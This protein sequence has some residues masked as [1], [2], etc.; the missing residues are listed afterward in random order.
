MSRDLTIIAYKPLFVV[1]REHQ[2]WGAAAGSRDLKGAGARAGKNIIGS[3][4][5]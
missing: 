3:H 1:W 2:C 4:S 5:R